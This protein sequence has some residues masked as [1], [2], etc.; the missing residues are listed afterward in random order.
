[1]TRRTPFAN[2]IGSL[3]AVSAVLALSLATSE[4]QAQDATIRTEAFIS[5][6]NRT[7]VTADAHMGGCGVRLADAVQEETGLNCPNN[8]VTFSCIGTHTTKA[9]AMRLFDSAQLAFVTGRRVAVWVDDVRKHSG[10][11]FASR[12][13]VLSS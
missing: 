5:T 2:R 3:C 7:R 10:F 13:D 1:M 8:W 6:V 4:A 12:L 11:C 9:N